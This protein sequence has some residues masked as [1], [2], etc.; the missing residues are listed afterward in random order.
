MLPPL[1]I[2]LALMKNF[3]KKISWEGEAYKCLRGKFP[4]LSEAKVKEGI[5]IGPQIQKIFRDLQLYDVLH[6]NKKAAWESFKSI[7]SHFLGKRRAPNYNKVVGEMLSCYEKVGC[8][9]SKN[10]LP[11]AHTDF[12]PENC[13][14]VSDCLLYTSRCV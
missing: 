10:L 7:C 14:S 1:H 13:A 9:M 11:P 4:Q 12:F 8:T 3:V 5:F 2:T 6:G